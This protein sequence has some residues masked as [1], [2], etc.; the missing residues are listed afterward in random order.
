MRIGFAEVEITPPVGSEMIGIFERRLMS[1]VHD[2]LMIVAC[3]MD[4]GQRTVAIVGVDVGVIERAMTDS[5]RAAITSATGIPVDHVLIGASHTHQG[6][7]VLT[8]FNYVGDP[9]YATRISA[10][11]AK[12]VTDAWNERREAHVAHGTG[13]VEG[14]HFNRRF[15]MRDGSEATHPGKLHPDIVCPAG[16]VDPDV[17]ILLS[18]TPDGSPLGAIVHFGCHATVTE[19]GNEYSAD[20]IHY[21]RR[22]L[23]QLLDKDVPVAFLLGACGDVTQVN[24]LSEGE[25]C[26]H[27]HADMMGGKLAHAAF[28][29]IQHAR[30]GTSLLISSRIEKTPI[31][32][33]SESEADRE[34][35]KIGLSSRDPW[36]AIYEKE[37]AFV[38]A[39][40]EAQPVI[41]CEVQAM[42]IGTLGIVSTGSELFCQPA[43]DIK[44]ASPFEQTWVVTLANEYLCYVPTGTAFY[45]GGYEPRTARSSFLAPNAAQRLVEA[46]LRALIH[47]KD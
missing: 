28:D 34:A 32:V 18:R 15:K 39:L 31:H 10:A 16:P 33:R 43:L 41:D 11:I 4:D 2:P 47:V 25:E 9:A 6:G 7:R 5:A 8:L 45:A 26:G 23:C 27:E 3:V 13:Q 19:G 21:F 46:S 38:D 30:F 22:H 1:G 42:G 40:R 20:Y 17:G 29:A 35:P 24:N 37:K 44:R 12:A 14:I 36:P